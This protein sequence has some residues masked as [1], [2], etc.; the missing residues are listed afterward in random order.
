MVI[1]PLESQGIDKMNF[2]NFWKTMIGD[3]GTSKQLITLKQGKSFDAVYR[4]GIILITPSTLN[5]RT[6]TQEQFLQVWQMAKTL[7]NEQQFVRQNYNQITLNG[8]YMLALMR[9]YLNDESIQ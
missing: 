2:G 1:L 7:P 4:N 9:K 3:L 8:S 6:I 5:E